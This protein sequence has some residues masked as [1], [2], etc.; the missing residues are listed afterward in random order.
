[1]LATFACLNGSLRGILIMSYYNVTHMYLPNKRF[2]L[3]FTSL[4]FTSLHFTREQTPLSDT[5]CHATAGWSRAAG[6]DRWGLLSSFNGRM[7][8]NK[9]TT[10]HT[11]FIVYSN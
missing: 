7:A 4:H 3:H 9:S 6:F 1:M 5:M 2:S 10:V 8:D 11:P